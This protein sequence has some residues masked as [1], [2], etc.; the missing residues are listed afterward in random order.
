MVAAAGEIRIGRIVSLSIPLGTISPALAP[1]RGDLRHQIIRSR[2]GRDDSLDGFYLQGASQWDGLQHIRYREHGYY[3]GRQEEDLDE[4]WLGIDAVARSGVVG[5][6]VLVDVERYRRLQSEPFDL[7]E[8]VP[9]EPEL[10][11][12]ALSAQETELVAGDILVL[13]TGWLGWYRSLDAAGREALGG[14][15]RAGDGALACPGLDP[16][17]ETAAWL[18]D[19]RVSAVAADNPA[20]EVLPVRREEGFLHRRLLPLLGMPI[21]EL[22]ALDE[23]AAVCAEAQRW[24]FFLSSVPLHLPGGA[25]SPSNGLAVL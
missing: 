15:L 1:G 16:G 4:G 10:L 13:R 19:R 23:L 14:T 17:A 7:S 8:R 20:L 25:G 12:E 5:R 3:G 11:D 2:H 9:I 6:G 24:S 21:G 18:W 22:W